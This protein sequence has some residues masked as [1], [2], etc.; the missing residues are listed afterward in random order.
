[1]SFR[2][3]T[4]GNPDAGTILIQMVDDHDLEGMQQEVSAVRELSGKQEF[5]LKAVRADRWNI[6]LSPWPA[7][8][9]FGR[10]WGFRIGNAC[11]SA[12]RNYFRLPVIR[13]TAPK[14]V[15]EPGSCRY[16]IP[17][18]WASSLTRKPYPSME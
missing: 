15:T 4:F 9:V 17:A 3:E 14:K 18:F 1:M 7:S 5:C 11:L 16:R 2:V 13:N 6:D 12:E 8:A 10:F